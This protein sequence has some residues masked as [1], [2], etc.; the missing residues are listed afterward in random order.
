MRFLPMA[1]FSDLIHKPANSLILQA[2]WEGGLSHVAMDLIRN[3]MRVTKVVLNTAD[4]IYKKRGVPTVSYDKPFENFEKWLR[5]YISQHNVDCIILYNQ[6]R[7]Y[8]QVGWDVAEEL[9]LECIVFELGLLRPDF[10]TIYNRD[11]DHFAYLSKQWELI[12]RGELTVGK[13]DDVQQLARMRTMTKMKQFAAFFLFSR[14]MAICFRQYTH[15]IDQRGQGIWH[16]LYCAIVSGLR[17]QG[18]VK[19]DRYDVKFASS[20]DKKYYFVPLQVHTDS[21]ITKRSDFESIEDFIDVVVGSFIAN[22][23]VGTKLVLKVHP[24]DRGYKDY[25]KKIKA[26]NREIGGNRIHYVDRVQL[27]LALGHCLGCITINSS[28]GLSG[29]IH[30]KKTIC[31]GESAFG[32][33]GLTY[34]GELDDFWQSD[35]EP[36]SEDV[37]NFLNILKHTSQAQGVLFQKL[38]SVK[39]Y[40]KIAWPDLFKP[41]FYSED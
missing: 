16:H 20:W 18:R 37:D 4:W 30:R 15:Y 39:G 5:E 23:P 7:P 29:V 28:V 12:K 21:Q 24:M 17:Y 34:Q 10:C 9:G 38:Y 26:L 41:L 2:D 13:S 19:H 27:P 22:A 31:L 14:V 33:E 32:L 36:I 8:N 11:C 40:C 25:H 6:Y 35:F 1:S 3:G